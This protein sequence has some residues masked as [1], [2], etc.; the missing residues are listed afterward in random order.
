[1]AILAENNGGGN[2]ERELIPAGIQVARC[3]SMIEIGTVAETWE[4]QSKLSKKVRLTFE[5]P[6]EMRVF[7]PENGEQPMSISKT[8]TLSMHEKAG[9]RK[10]L[11]SWRGKTY[12][13]A[14]ALKFDVSKLL[15]AAGMLTI[16]HTDKEGKTYANIQAVA[17]V[18]KGMTCPD[19]MNPSKIL[20]YDA[21]DWDVYNE[22]PK[23]LQ[24]QIASTPEYGRIQAELAARQRAGQVAQT[25]QPQ[26]EDGFENLPF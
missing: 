11:E 3:Y 19:Q 26:T 22:L 5:L 13:E 8:F 20:S 12:T 15:G 16:T 25:P 21:F 4:G 17:P 9:L 18:M 1:M 24:D 6:N 2:F 14:E 23:F 10:F 7:K